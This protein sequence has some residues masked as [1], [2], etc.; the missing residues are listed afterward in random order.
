MTSLYLSIPHVSLPGLLPPDPAAGAVWRGRSEAAG[1]GGRSR[2][3]EPGN[4]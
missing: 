4:P 3:R 2:D 1:P